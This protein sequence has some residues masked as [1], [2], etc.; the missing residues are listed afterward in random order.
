MLEQEQGGHNKLWW[1]VRQGSWWVD[2]WGGGGGGGQAP[3]LANGQG[4]EP[5][6]DDP[7]PA[8][9]ILKYIEKHTQHPLKT[10]SQGCVRTEETDQKDNERITKLTNLWIQEVMMRRRPPPPTKEGNNGERID[11]NTFVSNTGT[12]RWGDCCEGGLSD[13]S[14]R[15][16]SDFMP[17]PPSLR[18]FHACHWSE[19]DI[20]L[21][22]WWSW[23]WSENDERIFFSHKS[24]HN[25]M[26]T[27][28]RGH[29]PQVGPCG[30][31]HQAVWPR[32]WTLFPDCAHGWQ[33]EATRQHCILPVFGRK[34]EGGGVLSLSLAVAVCLA[35]FRLHAKHHFCHFDWQNWSIL[36]VLCFFLPR[37]T[38]GFLHGTKV[39]V[40]EQS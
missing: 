33:S 8:Y 26:K 22:W 4:F 37:G 24:P 11:T 7:M 39:F 35:Q 15:L 20:K 17:V 6:M 28:T 29:S 12:L 9:C 25:T 18:W 5:C 2:E 19:N 23:W 10:E 32:F 36:C 38:L 13:L 30:A 3:W 34:G 14:S 27:P 16:S 40:N 1:W 31:G 21:W